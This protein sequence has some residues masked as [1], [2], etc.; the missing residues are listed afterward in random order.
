MISLWEPPVIMTYENSPKIQVP[1]EI[2]KISNRLQDKMMM[3]TNKNWPVN[4]F[5]SKGNILLYIT[6]F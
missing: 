3:V 4:N 1:D 5:I 2:P 6:V